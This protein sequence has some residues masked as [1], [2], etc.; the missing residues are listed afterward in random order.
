MSK[1]KNMKL[2]LKKK[3][4]KDYFFLPF[5]LDE[6]LV[7]EDVAIGGSSSASCDSVAT[8]GTAGYA[9]GAGVTD[10]AAADASL[11]I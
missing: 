10:G 8:S 1:K 5:F 9:G 6:G 3:D 11:G 7:L 2:K 4:T